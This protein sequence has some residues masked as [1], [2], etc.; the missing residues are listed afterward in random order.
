MNRLCQEYLE[1]TQESG[2]FSQGTNRLSRFCPIDAE[3][4]LNKRLR[5]LI[6]EAENKL[7][8][9]GGENRSAER[10]LSSLLDLSELICISLLPN[11]A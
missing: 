6:A 1:R 10:L 11:Y 7:P 4:Q 3:S 5:S 8:Y 9:L 2:W